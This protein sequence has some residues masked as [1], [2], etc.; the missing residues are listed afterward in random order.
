MLWGG[1]TPLKVSQLT[2][3]DKDMDRAACRYLNFKTLTYE[4]EFELDEGALAL[5]TVIMN[6]KAKTLGLTLV[7]IRALRQDDLMLKHAGQDGKV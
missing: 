6:D 7:D 5:Q 2:Y 1:V 4:R 3:Q